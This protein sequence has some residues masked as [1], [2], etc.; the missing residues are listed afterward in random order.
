MAHPPQLFQHGLFD[1]VL[2]HGDPSPRP[3]GDAEP[4]EVH[5][6]LRID[7]PRDQVHRQLQVPLRLHI[8]AH[9]GQGRVQPVRVRVGEDP[10]DD[11]VVRPPAGRQRIGVRGVE[12]EAVPAVLE[13]EAAPVGDEAGAEA[14]E[15]AVDEADGVA[16][17]VHDLEGH[18]AGRRVRLPL[19]DGPSGIER[20]EGPRRDALLVQE[21]VGVLLGVLLPFRVTDEG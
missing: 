14:H 12:V 4:G 16:G 1:A 18:R 13:G 17:P 20:G 21:P 6:A 3:V 7:P 2:Y 10:G 9:V 19:G 15:V 8:P 5:G 11:G